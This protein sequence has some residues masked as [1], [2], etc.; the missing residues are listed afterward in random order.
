MLILWSLQSNPGSKQSLYIHLDGHQSI[1][2]LLQNLQ[3][4]LVPIDHS[5]C[6]EES[7]HCLPIY[8]ADTQKLFQKGL[9]LNKTKLIPDKFQIYFDFQQNKV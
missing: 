1:Q 2:W 4:R 5:Q 9:F 7:F 6:I 3:L 8:V